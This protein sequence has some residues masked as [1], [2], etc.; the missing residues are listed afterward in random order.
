MDLLE[1]ANK[2]VQ[3]KL[4]EIAKPITDKVVKYTTQF[5]SDQRFAVVVLKAGFRR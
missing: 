4:S 5:L 2:M 1:R 3:D